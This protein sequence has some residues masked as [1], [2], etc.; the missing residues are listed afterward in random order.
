MMTSACLRPLY[1]LVGNAAGKR[2]FPILA[3]LALTQ[4]AWAAGAASEVDLS[5]AQTLIEQRRYDDA[6]GLLAPNA[7]KDTSSAQLAY[8]MGRA[9]LGRG[10]AEQAREWLTRSLQLQADFID[11]H[12]AL[13][14]A[15]YRLGMLAEARLAFETV[16]RFDNLPPDL[17]SQVRIYSQA[18]SQHLE[19]GRRLVSF[20]YAMMGIGQYWVNP[21]KGTNALGGNDRRDTFYNAR[22]GGGLNYELADNYALDGSLDYRFRYYDNPDSRNDSDLRWRAAVSRAENEANI[23]AG[24]F[25]RVSYRGESTYRNDYGAFADYRYRLD[26]DNQISVGGE[27][28][29][30]RYPEGRLR[31]R[32]F[33]TAVANVGWVRAL[34]DG[35]A[36]FSLKAHAGYNFATGRPDGDSMVYGLTGNLDFTLTETVSGFVFGW[37]EHDSFDAERIHFHPDALDQI[38]SLQRQDNLYEV[39][40]GLVWDLGGGWSLRPEILFTRDQSNAVAV[41]YSAT[42]AWM[43]LRVDF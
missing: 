22:V 34:A 43:N 10:Q 23:A 11:A 9:A 2:W 38:V 1:Q 35:Q 31:Q 42:E 20:G 16:F 6:Y 30:R 3:A 41:N 21:T 26:A 18:A 7:A 37:W 29:R 4:S 27:V 33:S 40:A 13:G 12:L 25:G 5:A 24:I 32:T 19:G 8:L 36:S 14:Q 39:G 28:R 17:E 15:Y